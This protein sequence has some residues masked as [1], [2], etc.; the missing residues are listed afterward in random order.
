M[1]SKESPP[2]SPKD[3]L[4]CTST[5][6]SRSCPKESPPYPPISTKDPPPCPPI[7]TKDSPPCP[8]DLDSSFSPW[9]SLDSVNV[10]A[11]IGEVGDYLFVDKKSICSLCDKESNNGFKSVKDNFLFCH[12]CLEEIDPP[13]YYLYLWNTDM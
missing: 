6:D 2:F 3:P 11:D 1:N 13:A 8:K 7:S 10:K 4:P 9:D 12:L 5:K